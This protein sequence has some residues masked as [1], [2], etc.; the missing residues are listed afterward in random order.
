MRQPCSDILFDVLVFFAEWPAWLGWGDFEN[1]GKEAR[2]AK[3]CMVT[4]HSELLLEFFSVLSVP[5]KKLT[6]PDV[7]QILV[8]VLA[9]ILTS[10]DTISKTNPTRLVDAATGG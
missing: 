8:K 5:A 10:D 6:L 1:V 3:S 7:K 9:L 2:L 4:D